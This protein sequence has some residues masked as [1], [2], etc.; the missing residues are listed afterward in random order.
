MVRTAAASIGLVIV[1]ISCALHLPTIP[2]A[3]GPLAPLATVAAPPGS[4]SAMD[5]LVPIPLHVGYGVRGSWFELYFTDPQ[6]PASGQ[7]SG[8][9]DSP[10]VQAIDDARL[11]VHAAM[12]S[13]TL[14]SVRDA[15]VRAWRRGIDVKVVMESDNLDA[16][17][18]QSLK[19]AGVPILGDRR[20]GLMHDKFMIID[21]GEVWTGSMNFTNSGAYLDNNVLMRLRS[22]ELAADYESEF[23]EMFEDDHFGS[24]PGRSTPFP[25]VTLDGSLVRVYFS[26]DDHV[27]QALST[28]LKGAKS[29]IDFLAYSFTLNDLGADLVNAKAAGV[30]VSGVMDADQAAS[31]QGTEL[32]AFK[33][34]GLDVKMDGNPNQMHEKAVIVDAQTVAFGSYNFSSSAEKTNDENLIIIYDAGIA[35][36]F[37]QEFHRVYTM[38]GN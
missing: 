19:D 24:D 21:G 26:P 14:H 8:G 23:A 37:L 36:Q 27:E 10:L 22:R 15:L 17:E 25:N 20:E 7:F 13:L 2:V 11:S 30:Q 18:P 38:A 33:A 28:L 1:S 32:P 3:V 29:S 35:R 34:A 12:Y 6:N 9:I 31:N 16:R 5:E 4:A